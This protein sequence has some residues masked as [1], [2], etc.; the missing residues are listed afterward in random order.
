[1]V[2][3]TI[4]QL[5]EETERFVRQA[6]EEEIQVQADGRVLAVLS[7]PRAPVEFEAYWRRRE[8]VLSRVSLQGPWDSTQAVS[9]DRGGR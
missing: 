1:M 4:Q 5:H 7:R 3:I 8:Q 6:G 2:T 9:E